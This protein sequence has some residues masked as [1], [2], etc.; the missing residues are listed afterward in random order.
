MVVAWLTFILS[1][2]DHRLY[3]VESWVAAHQHTIS[4]SLNQE[5][6][7]RDCTDDRLATGLADLCVAENWVECELNQTLIRVYDLHPCPETK[8]IMDFFRNNAGTLCNG[9]DKSHAAIAP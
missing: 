6:L 3:Q 4:R 8:E 2:G 1:E 5:V 7:P 9:P